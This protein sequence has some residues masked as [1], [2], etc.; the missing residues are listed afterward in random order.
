MA[1]RYQVRATTEFSAA[2][3]LR[4]Y[5]GACER[6]HGH[7]FA[8]EALVEVRELDS[9]GMAVDFT[10]LEAKLASITQQLDH[11]F[12]NEVDPFTE[13]N[14]TAEN[15]AAYVW[16]HLQDHLPTL[17]PGRSARLREVTVRENGRTAVTLASDDA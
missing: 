17:A 10:A 9:V 4:G 11:C 14:P 5:A 15:I 7:N 2:H 1:R 12:L 3:V 8:V 16:A 13:V 6:L